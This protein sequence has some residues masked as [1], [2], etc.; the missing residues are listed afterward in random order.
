MGL[1]RRE[2]GIDCGLCP[3]ASIAFGVETPYR[4]SLFLGSTEFGQ[5]RMRFP[6]FVTY[7]SI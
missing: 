7:V 6:A 1:R 4:T 3:D 5:N 2:P